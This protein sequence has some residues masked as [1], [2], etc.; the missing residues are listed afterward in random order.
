VAGPFPLL[1]DE[2]ISKALIKTLRD[3]GW[4]VVCAVDV[5]GQRTD[6][7]ILFEHAAENGR[8]LVTTDAGLEAIAIRWLREWRV[9]PGLVIWAQEHQRVMSE[10]DFLRE[11]EELAAKDEA[12]A[13]PV[14]HI[15]PRR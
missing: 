2:H 10:G 5:F 9:F 6:D 4:N 8:V 11:F 7:Q 15:K 1:T 14:H 13:Y 12:F 3:H